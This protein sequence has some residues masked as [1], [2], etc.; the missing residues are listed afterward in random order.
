MPYRFVH[1]A[2]LHLDSPLRSLALLDQEL[3]QLIGTATRQAFERIVDLCLD[4]RVD[5]LLIAGDLYDG[6]QSSMKTARFLA[7]QLAKLHTAGITVFIIRGNHDAAAKITNELTMPDNVH[8]FR[9]RAAAV[10]AATAGRP[11]VVHGISFNPTAASR[12]PL[13]RFKPPV[14]GATNIGLLHTSLGGAPGHDVYAPCSPGELA[15]TGFDYWALGHIHQRSVHRGRTT[16]VMPGI[17][18]GRDVNEAGSKSATL[19]TVADDGGITLEDRPTA[20]A[21]FHRVRVAMDGVDTWPDLLAAVRRALACARQTTTAPHLVT[22]LELAGTSPL[23][24]RARRDADL[25]KEEAGLEARRVGDTWIEKI[26]LACTKPDAGERAD[27]SPLGALGHLIENDIL[28]SDA[29]ATALAAHAEQLLARLPAEL[30]DLLG[31]DEV[32]TRD[33]LF[34]LAREGV[35]D[36]LAR[37]E[38]A[39]ATGDGGES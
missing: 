9:G 21:E 4:E 29:F 36:V 39:E 35:A 17:P 22:R 11:V 27:G 32:T 31:D 38:V 3:A 1:T 5:A 24:W 10:E 6:E 37:L 26:E 13:D 33:Q 20:L 28:P 15:E 16:A 14:D 30:R 34:A 18:Q 23:A 7:E 19:V 2:D 12:N 25:L 8:V